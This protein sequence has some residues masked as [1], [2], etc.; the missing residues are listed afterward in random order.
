MVQGECK[1]HSICTLLLSAFVDRIV[2]CPFFRGLAFL[3]DLH[4]EGPPHTHTHIN[5]TIIGSHYLFLQLSI[6]TSCLLAYR[7]MVFLSTYCADAQQNTGEKRQT[8][9]VR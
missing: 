9:V 8:M 1:C 7:M 2:Q 4:Q 6:V 5:K 3:T